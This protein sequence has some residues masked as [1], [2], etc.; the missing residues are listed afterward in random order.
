MLQTNREHFR[1]HCTAQHDP[2]RCKRQWIVLE[3]TTFI[4]W[5]TTMDSN[6]TGSGAHPADGR[7]HLMARLR[8]HADTPDITRASSRRGI[9]LGTGTA[10]HT[11]VRLPSLNPRD[12]WAAAIFQT[13]WTAH[14][15][16]ELRE[17]TTVTCRIV[18]LFEIC[19]W[20]R[21]PRKL[22]TE[23]FEL[24]VLIF[25]LRR[26][27]PSARNRTDFHEVWYLRIFRKSVVK[28]KFH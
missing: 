10:A 15:R 3:D 9:W 5:S 23:S 18:Q 13:V 1:T 27:V 16:S 8:G 7:L 2:S 26:Y 20:K 24:H 12:R 28:F 21:A 4:S 22:A 6:Q 14:G 19:T 25:R 17:Q 11:T